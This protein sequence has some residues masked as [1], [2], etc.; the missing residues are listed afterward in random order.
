MS[1]LKD[2]PGTSR[3][4][5]Q[6]N[7]NSWAGNGVFA[8]T[9]FETR[10]DEVG[11][12]FCIKSE[13]DQRGLWDEEG[14]IDYVRKFFQGLTCSEISTALRL[15]ESCDRW[16]LAEMPDLPRW[17]SQ[18]G[19]VVLLGDCAH[20]MHPNAGQGYSQIVE[21]VGA[22]DYLL[23]ELHP[24]KPIVAITSAWQDTRKP[25]VERIRDF[26]RWNTK[27]F[28]GELGFKPSKKAAAKSSQISYRDLKDVRPDMSAPFFSATFLKWALDYDAVDEV[29][30][31]RCP[32]VRQ[33]TDTY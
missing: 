8:I 18:G 28:S 13:T 30:D 23:A 15:A 25:R 32:F 10:T 19:R 5:D 33:P 22:L 4:Y 24:R 6:T 21:D 31:R 11:I 3:L 27:V 9:R 16:K 2:C 7:T 26:A 14:D 17:T 1:K 12:L 20:G 29:C